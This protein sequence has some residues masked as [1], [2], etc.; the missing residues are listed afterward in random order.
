MDRSMCH[1]LLPID[2][3]NS[4]QDGSIRLRHIKMDPNSS[5]FMALALCFNL[6]IFPK[7][8]SSLSFDPCELNS[9]E[10]NV[11]CNGLYP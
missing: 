5:T 6:N 1:N 8:P 4:S 11:E 3:S 10:A 9:M 7:I 2:S